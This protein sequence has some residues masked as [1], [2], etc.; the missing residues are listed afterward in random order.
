MKT[1]PDVLIVGGGVIGICSAYYLAE[2]GASVSLVEMNEVASGCSRSNAGLIVP[3][4]I[5]PLASPGVLSQGLKWM[6]KS[7]SPFYIRPR[8][9]LSLVQWLWRFRKACGS[10]KMPRAMQALHE[11]S[12]ASS[13]LFQDLIA[14][15]SLACDY[16][17]D[18]WL[19]VYKTRTGLNKALEEARLLERYSVEMKLLSADETIAMEP[20]L[21]SDISGGIF[22]PEDSHL[23][24]AK[25]AHAVADTLSKKGV[26]IHEHTEA[27]EFETSSKFIEAVR[28]T[29]GVLR[30][31]QVLLAAG[32]WSSG[33][34][35]KLGLSLALQPGKG[36]SVSIK[37]PEPCPR[38]P[39]YLSETK[40]A[41]TPLDDTLR[42][43][44]TLEFVGMD[45]GLNERRVNAIKRAAGEYL[46]RM[47]NL[48]SGEIWSGLRPCSPDGLPLIGR[49]RA[50]ENL[51][52]ATG[53]GMLG[54]SLAPITGKLVSKLPVDS[55][56]ILISLPYLWPD[57]GVDITG[58]KPARN[59]D[60][61]LLRP[62]ETTG[63]IT[64]DGQRRL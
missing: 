36:Y 45:F 8:L 22:Y 16:R 29:A 40:V 15:E 21:K 57:L 19:M 38:I 46:G 10:R 30:P 56:R 24:P 62:P 3:S 51:I 27:I 12:S 23:D 25:F 9:N 6:L 58:P 35:R 43:G 53:H 44:G 42:F 48:E 17:Q 39:L 47:E 37:R 2:Q 34:G 50:L 59:S 18:G 28:T 61:H 26:E 5:I 4:Y 33:L 52:V 63:M 41:V 1:E 7:D 13:G 49:S 11:L 64:W 55:P 32:S 20:M 14:K 60:A 31:K 54:I